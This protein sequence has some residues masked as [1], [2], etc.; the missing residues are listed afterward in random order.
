MTKLKGRQKAK[1]RK[2]VEEILSNSNTNLAKLFDPAIELPY[3]KDSGRTKAEVQKRILNENY[4]DT[5][6]GALYQKEMSLQ[7]SILALTVILIL[8]ALFGLIGM[9][10]YQTD[11]RTKEIGIRKVNGAT[12]K[13]II[14]LLNKGFIKWVFIAFIIACPF[15]YYALSTWLENFAY[16]T[17]ISW[18]I[19]AL[20]GLSTLFIALLTVSWQSYKAATNNPIESLRDE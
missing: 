20:A 1:A 9:S 19:F 3:L 2:I 18:W 8:I 12:I 6:N 4:Q 5:I 11:Q 16:K 7:K 17:N 13:E 14:Y 10:L 15:A